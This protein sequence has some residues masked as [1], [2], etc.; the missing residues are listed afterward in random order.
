MPALAKHFNPSQT[1][2]KIFLVVIAAGTILLLLPPMTNGSISPIDALFTATSAVCVTGLTV[3]DTGTFFTIYGQIVIL[4]LI[5]IGALGYMSLASLLVIL[6]RKGMSIKGRLLVQH[7]MSGNK[8]MKLSRFIL[9]VAVLTF[10]LETAGA[11]ILYTRFKSMFSDSW[12]ALY[13]GIFHSVSAFC[14]AGFDIFGNG[15]SLTGIRGDHISLMVF[16]VLII[17][18]GIGYFVVNDIFEYIRSAGQ[19]KKHRLSVH[20]KLVLLTTFILLTL[21]TAVFFAAEFNNPATIGAMSLPQ[22]LGISF[23]QAVTP[24]TAGFSMIDTSGLINFSIIFTIILMFIGASPGGTGGG[25]KTT[26]FALILL[27]IKSTL[28]EDEDVFIHGRRIKYWALK[29]AMTLFVLGIMIVSGSVLL[30]SAFDSFGFREI[31]FETVSAFGTVGLSLGITPGLSSA[32][33]LVII[34]TMLFGRVGPLT[35]GAAFVRKTKK[36]AY[37]Y[38][39]QEIAIG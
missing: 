35:F 13:Y 20:T 39:E 15:R 33:K 29:K 21:G 26:T 34:A 6:L 4:L 2:I 37:R 25:I 38:P 17:V 12:Q 24:R 30:I 8:S 9:R 7:Q 28:K 32:G 5:Q 11:V 3:H 19:K 23:F 22:K 18:G 10:S 14:N 1:L 36:A 31:L 16:S 27:N